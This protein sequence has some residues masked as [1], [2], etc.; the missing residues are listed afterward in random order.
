MSVL[1]RWIGAIVVGT[2]GTVVLYLWGWWAVAGALVIG[3]VIAGM[4]TVFEE[5]KDGWDEKQDDDDR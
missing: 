2:I 5:E 4:V 1:R 3:A